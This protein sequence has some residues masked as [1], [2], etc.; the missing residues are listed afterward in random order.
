MQHQ[1]SSG[2][3][4]SSQNASS[5]PNL[6]L[7]SQGRIH[8]KSLAHASKVKLGCGPDMNPFAGMTRWG[9]CRS[10]I[11]GICRMCIYCDMY[12]ASATSFLGGV[13]SSHLHMST[14][15]FQNMVR[16]DVSHAE[17]TAVAATRLRMR[18][19]T[20][21]RPGN[22]LANFGTKSHTKS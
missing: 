9:H 5:L 11:A 2:P 12:S 3:T 10:K 7:M 18:K 13:C 8:K 15:G 4:R 6:A 1:G 21:T 16:Q 19:R 22:S 20:L 17:C 14:S